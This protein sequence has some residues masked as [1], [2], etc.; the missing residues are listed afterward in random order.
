MSSKCD[1]NNKTQLLSV[2]LRKALEDGII[3][4]PN[5]C[6]GVMP[7]DGIMTILLDVA[8]LSQQT[9]IKKHA[10]SDESLVSLNAELDG[11]SMSASWSCEFDLWSSVKSIMCTGT[12][13]NQCENTD[14]VKQVSG[15]GLPIAL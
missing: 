5:S 4:C 14:H 11:N 7:V 9:T 3:H 13:H 2:L 1:D 8:R 12:A 6:S 10:G 15:L